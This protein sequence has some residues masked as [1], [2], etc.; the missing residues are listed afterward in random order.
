MASFLQ[1]LQTLEEVSACVVVATSQHCPLMKHLHT[2]PFQDLLLAFIAPNEVADIAGLVLSLK[3][4]MR[5]LLPS[6]CLPDEVVLVKHLPMSEH[7][8]VVV[9]LHMII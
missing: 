1:T 9:L 5:G 7:G 8:K 6:Y 2:P 4:T 3:S